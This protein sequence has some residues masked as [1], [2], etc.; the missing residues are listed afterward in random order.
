MIRFLKLTLLIALGWGLISC[1]QTKSAKPQPTKKSSNADAGD[2][3]V[4]DDPDG[5]GLLDPGLFSDDADDEKDTNEL[6]KNKS[7][8]DISGQYVDK[9]LNSSDTLE[10]CYDS[11]GRLV[12]VGNQDQ[13][14][15]LDTLKQKFGQEIIYPVQALFPRLYQAAEAQG[16]N[17]EAFLLQELKS[18][19]CQQLSQ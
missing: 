18:K 11:A 9:S 6:C 8:S 3:S 7:G 16:Q 14:A 5:Q 1:T 10:D 15:C 12:Y 17:A 19:T 4:K 2:D 13:G